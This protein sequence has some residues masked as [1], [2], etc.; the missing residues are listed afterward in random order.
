MRPQRGPPRKTPRSAPSKKTSRPEDSNPPTPAPY[1]PRPAA[2]LHSSV[3]PEIPGV[4]GCTMCQCTERPTPGFGRK[5]TLDVP[6]AAWHHE[7]TLMTTTPAAAIL[8]ARRTEDWSGMDISARPV[9]AETA[10]CARV[11]GLVAHHL[12]MLPTW[13]PPYRRCQ[14]PGR[15][16]PDGPDG[17]DEPAEGRTCGRRKRRRAG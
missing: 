11:C 9:S 1:P 15:P 13:L 8:A 6:F 17:G 14:R 5:I 10:G 3:H 2:I 16:T 7:Q 4:S 12:H